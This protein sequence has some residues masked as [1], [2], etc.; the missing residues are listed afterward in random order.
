MLYARQR[1]HDSFILTDYGIS[2]DAIVHLVLSLLIGALGAN[3]PSS[4]PP[5]SFK[6]V[7]N[8]GFF[9]PS[10]ETKPLN[11][12]FI[13]EKSKDIPM[14]EVRDPEVYAYDTLYQRDA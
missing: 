13:V 9:A 14:L 12:A 5:Y 2:K 3:A 7:V 1:L 6:D 8:I 4:S 10:K 11:P